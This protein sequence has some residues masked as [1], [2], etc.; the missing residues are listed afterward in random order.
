MAILVMA[1]GACGSDDR[2]VDIPEV[3]AGA[4]EA[5]C[6][7]LCTR[8]AGDDGCSAKHAAFC[9]ASCRVRTN[10]MTAACGQCLITEGD[11]IHSFT[12]SFGDLSCTVGGAAGLDACRTECDDAGAAPPAASLSVLCDLECKFYMQDPEPL[13]C[14]ADGSAACLT[15][16]SGAVTNQN[17]VCAQC[18]IEGVIP[19]K[20]CINDAC[21]CDPFFQG[22]PAVRCA[23]LCDDRPPV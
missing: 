17:R 5:G 3:E 10:G 1:L 15:E 12:D 9:L 23:S 6:Q 7:T 2:P 8:M 21:D 16:C 4:F 19:S 20:G 22:D 14:S 13:A 18:L 11:Q